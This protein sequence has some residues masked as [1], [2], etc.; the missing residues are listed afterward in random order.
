MRSDQSRMR[1]LNCQVSTSTKQFA[2]ATDKRNY[3]YVEASGATPVYVRF[4]EPNK[5]S[6]TGAN[7]D[8]TIPAGQFKEW[9]T[10]VPINSVN[11]SSPNGATTATLVEGLELNSKGF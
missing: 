7:G 3:L 8:I 1:H 11:L 5:A 6:T 4:D 2:P 9:K 10:K